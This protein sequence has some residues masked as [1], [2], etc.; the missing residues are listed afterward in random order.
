MLQWLPEY[1]FFKKENFDKLLEKY[2]LQNTSY[3][4]QN[5]EIVTDI[6]NALQAIEDKWA[7]EF[8]RESRPVTVTIAPSL[9]DARFNGREITD[10]E[11]MLNSTHF[12]Y[13]NRNYQVAWSPGMYTIPFE[14]I[15]ALWHESLHCS[16]SGSNQ[17]SYT[18]QKL[19][20][21]ERELQD[22]TDDF[23]W[24]RY[25]E[26]TARIG[27]AKFLMALST[28]MKEHLSADDLQSIGYACQALSGRLSYDANKQ[29]IQKLGRALKRGLRAL[30]E[31]NL[32]H[33][34]FPKN[35]S[36]KQMKKEARACV[37]DALKKDGHYMRALSQLEEV[38]QA[39]D[40]HA[41]ALQ[42][43]IDEAL[44]KQQHQE[45]CER[46]TELADK[47]QIPVLEAFPERTE[48]G[49]DYYRIPIFRDKK[50][51]QH[52]SE[53][54]QYYSPAIVIPKNGNPVLIYDRTA[55]P[56][57]YSTNAALRMTWMAAHEAETS[58]LREEGNLHDG[59]LAKYNHETEEINNDEYVI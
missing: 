48:K 14:L 13:V 59:A 45:E 23:Y 56:R 43:V 31:E 52:I 35:Y 19:V 54:L 17:F 11:Q 5:H 20:W 4:P 12:D 1:E 51:E 34:G 41:V 39:L 44:Q 22:Q 2:N 29:Q 38:Q 28:D 49:D 53:A 7:A 55:V 27:E 25:G 15:S 18:A 32:L 33:N 42:P 57:P 36:L 24:C 26:I 3:I 46:L 58:I 16:Q 30:K 6:T 10:D 8:G 50:A 37:S 9:L 21:I 40:A 47:Y